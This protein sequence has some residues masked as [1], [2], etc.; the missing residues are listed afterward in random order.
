MSDCNWFTW[1]VGTW[2][3]VSAG[4]VVRE[5]AEVVG[6]VAEVVGEI[7]IVV[8]RLAEVVGRL[9]E[10]VGVVVDVVGEIAEVVGRVVASSS[11]LRPA[12]AYCGQLWLAT[13][14]Y[15]W[16]RLGRMTAI[17]HRLSSSGCGVGLHTWLSIGLRMGML[18]TA[19]VWSRGSH[20][21][22]RRHGRAS[23]HASEHA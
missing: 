21:V 13:S 22:M 7:T 17:V 2:S 15:G 9:T 16:P 1:H 6:D 8:G 20:E 11:Q 23:P 3:G 12:T 4:E 14:G 5:V 10:V 18:T 19:A